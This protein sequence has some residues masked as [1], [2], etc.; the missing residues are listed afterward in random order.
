MDSQVLMLILKLSM[1]FVPFSIGFIGLGINCYTACRDLDGILNNFKKSYVITSYGGMWG[2]GS[3]FSRC[4]L[5][6][7]VS[8]GVLWPKKHIRNG[9]LDP[10]ELA[11]LPA[12]IKLRMKWS[13]GLMFFGYAGLFAAVMISEL[14]RWFAGSG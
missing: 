13:V 8:G 11:C 9:M 6:S 12:S 3:F 14:L 4:I 1:I 2:G 5:T 10:E 7:I